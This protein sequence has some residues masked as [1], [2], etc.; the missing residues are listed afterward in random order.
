V[1]AESGRPAGGPLFQ[2]AQHPGGLPIYYVGDASVKQ[3][4][5]PVVLHRGDWA[6]VIAV[7]TKP[8][9]LA[10]TIKHIG[11]VWKSFL[12]QQEIRYHF[13]D[14]SFARMYADVKSNTTD[15]E[16]INGCRI[17]LPITGKKKGSFLRPLFFILLKNSYCLRVF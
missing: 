16:C 7:K 3:A 10:A 2:P 15:D 8:N 14:E 9:K 6:S 5:D 12:P 17:L 4:I 11:A 13:L 1:I